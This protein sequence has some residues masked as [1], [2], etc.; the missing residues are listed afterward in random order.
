MTKAI[1]S[2]SLAGAFLIALA[3][4]QTE[5]R[6]PQ[7]RASLDDQVRS[8][9]STFQNEDAGI[10]DWLSKSYAY[11]VFPSIGKGGAIVGGAYGRGEV[12]EQGRFIGYADLTQAT[13]GAQLGGQTFAELLC[14]ENRETLDTFRSGKFK[15]A[16][17][18]SA[19]AMKAGASA[20][21]RFTNG[22]AVFTRSQGGLMIEAAIGGQQF[23]F[24]PASAPAR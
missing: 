9:L 12:Y 21:N 13:I 23:T 14:L 19:V 20:T 16:A 10:N 24:I 17:N 7:D 15:F 5:P 8:S 6:T 2:M 11:V 22:V 4:C 18:A 3:G 1:V